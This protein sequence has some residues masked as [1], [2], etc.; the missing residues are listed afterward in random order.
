VLGT[1]AAF[2]GWELAVGVDL[3]LE[4]LEGLLA[5]WA[6]AGASVFGAAP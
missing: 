1:A 6:G 2:V 5:R 3:V 4:A